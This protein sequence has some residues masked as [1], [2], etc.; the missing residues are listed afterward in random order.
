M[1]AVQEGGH[2]YPA[3]AA[4]ELRILVPRS[5]WTVLNEIGPQFERTSGY[6]LNI[7]TEIAA[8]L[9]QRIN[10]GERF[11]VFI[12]PPHQM[13]QLV[14]NGK[15][16]ANTRT[17]IARSRIGIEVRAGDSKPDISSVDA[18]K[19]ALLN[20]KSIGYLKPEGTSGAYLAGLFDRLGIAEAIKSKIIR[21]ETDIV[22]ELV[23]KGEIELG[24]VVITQILTT[25]GVELVGPIPCE[26]QFYVAWSGGVSA[27]SAAP[28]VAKAL[29]KFLTGPTALPVL[30][31][32]GME[33][34]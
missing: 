6:K 4:A 7:V 32:Q 12:S 33:P 3:D 18:F 2:R 30:R 14:K 10:D 34:G 29:I 19:R 13:N 31:A 8:T 24:M 1:M 22:S 17:A 25:P 9:A 11:D 16:I 5:I 27:N 26:L 15:I 23:A 28:N 20:A 21:P